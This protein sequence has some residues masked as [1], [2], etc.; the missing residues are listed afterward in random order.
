MDRRARELKLNAAKVVLAALEARKSSRAIAT[1]MADLREA[2][3]LEA[4]QLRGLDLCQNLF[5]GL[6]ALD[7][8]LLAHAGTVGQALASLDKLAEPPKPVGETFR[9]FQSQSANEPRATVKALL[10][11]LT[12]A[13]EFIEAL[14][15][16]V[17]RGED[18]QAAG[19]KLTEALVRAAK[20]A[21]VNLINLLKGTG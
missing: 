6:G 4:A 15:G 17:G 21:E 18:H 7:K 2:L 13:R 5:D 12:Q 11:S 1:A 19:A 10:G 14:Q 16:E 3:H 9:S 20:V 8:Q